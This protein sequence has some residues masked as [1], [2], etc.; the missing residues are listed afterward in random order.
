MSCPFWSFLLSYG[1]SI[2]FVFYQ[3]VVLLSASANTNNLHGPGMALVFPHYSMLNVVDLPLLG[4][5]AFLKQKAELFQ[6]YSAL[7]PLAECD[8][9]PAT[10][11][12]LPHFHQ[13][14]QEKNRPVCW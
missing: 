11:L 1:Q 5:T 3:P 10:G 2:S 12:R 9:K 8:G 7:T 4:L 6:M 13:K 14:Q